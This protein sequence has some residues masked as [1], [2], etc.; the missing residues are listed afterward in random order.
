MLQFR[1]YFKIATRNIRRNK[2]FSFINLFGLSV[3]IAA[4][5][6]IILFIIDEL[7]YDKFLPKNENI[8]LLGVKGNFGGNEFDTYNTPPP[9]GLA[10]QTDYP[11]I[12][13][14]T[15]TH[16]PG[17]IMISHEKN[18]VIDHYYTETAILAADSNFLQ[19]FQFPL[20]AGD[21]TT[22]L[23]EPQSIVLTE[24][25]AAKYFGKAEAVGETVLFGNDKKPF[26]VT[27]VLKNIPKQSTLAFSA[28]VPMQTFSVVKYFDW[29][30]VWLN[31]NT[32]VKVSD[33]IAGNEAAIKKIEGQFPEMVKRRAAQSFERIG[34]P[35]DKF[36][37]EG[38][39]WDFNLTA[40]NK[41]HLYSAGKETNIKTLGS[42]KN[43]YIFGIIAAFIIVLA[44]VNFMNLSTAKSL[45]R[46]KEVG[47]RKVLGSKKGS[48]AMQFMFESFFFTLISVVI[49]VTLVSAFLPAFNTLSGKSFTAGQLLS[50]EL[51]AGIVLMG[52]LIGILAGIYPA[53]Y[54]SSFNPITVLKGKLSKNGFG[55][56]LI[57]NG[58]VV[59]QFAIS[60]SLIICTAIVYKQL[61]HNQQ[62]DIGL[63]KENLIYISNSQRLGK[64]E[65]TFRK[66]LLNLP[67]VAN[68]TITTNI[69]AGGAFGDR[70]IPE[71]SDK[72]KNLSPDI[73][74]YSYLVDEEFIPTMDIKI[75]QG[76]NF[77]KEFNDS[78]TVIL[79][80]T[81]VRQA[82]WKNPIGQ[83]ISYPGG[84][85]TKFT[86]IG[87]VKDFNV[88]SLHTPVVPFAIFHKSSKTYEEPFS[89]MAVRVKEGK[90]NAA[91]ASLENKWKSFVPATPFDFG[92]LDQRLD[93]LYQS[94]QQSGKIF[95]VFSVLSI[96]IA[97]LGL[98]GL[99]T[100]SAEQRINEI[101][102]RKVL[103]ASVG[104]ITGLLS[105]D[106]IRLVV[107][108]FIIA[109]PVAG[110]FMHEWLKD[111]AYR[112]NIEWW[113]FA[114][115]GI[116]A[117][118]IAVFTV[119]FQAIKAAVANP[120]KSLR[121]E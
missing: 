70:Y 48:L 109:S 57:R 92:F 100:F 55:N 75:K 59:F 90:T 117:I 95:A 45:K 118:A 61:K 98:F 44:C 11:G 72:E 2:V 110:Y 80:E 35:M 96:F 39:Y 116:I 77:S 119:S 86:I 17:D 20:L 10:V 19:L 54:L 121:S 32:Y 52:V 18:G 36:F 31:V 120:V 38:G 89:Y 113:I 62:M 15:R 12:E 114:L 46:A 14:Y 66:E 21:A 81:A 82:G 65:E 56:I 67:E 105:K 115:A 7:S 101:G 73:S 29:S 5:L 16:A 13:S 71:P 84:D 94:E 9:S 64:Q 87:V 22:C 78:A 107:I 33:A 34:M 97:C 79:N 8:Y 103:G 49:G 111:F 30:W 26:K 24:N 27:A 104:N 4:S 42:I 1:H 69:P 50:T 41:I 6:M 51:I 23:N 40:F 68:A 88:Q 106:F 83:T 63:D 60:T 58:L 53:L 47:I 112:T 85:Y 37:Q 99:A 74:L 3:G 102:I 91:I 43:L 76:R 108:A 93:K 25:M 28:I